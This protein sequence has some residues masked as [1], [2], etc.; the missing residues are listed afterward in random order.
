MKL[1]LLSLLVA[2]ITVMALLVSCTGNNGG[3]GDGNDPG[4]DPGQG[5]QGGS[6]DSKYDW[7]SSEILVQLYENSNNNELEPGVRRYYAG[8]D[9]AAFGDIDN[10]VRQRNADAEKTT[11]VDAKYTYETTYGWGAAVDYIQNTVKSGS[12]AAPDVFC[13]FA[14]DMTSCAIRGCCAG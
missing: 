6:G 14:Y 13:N 5:D 8:E 9:T 2:I 10:Y 3:G 12:S 7:A 11:K 1:K 4:N